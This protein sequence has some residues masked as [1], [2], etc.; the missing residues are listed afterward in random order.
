MII[1]QRCSL[2]ND[3]IITYLFIEDMRIDGDSIKI[4]LSMYHKF[5]KNVM[6]YESIIQRKL[7]NKYQS[8][9]KC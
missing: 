9:H 7:K 5:I 4:N 1:I 2:S 3:Y 8:S 6:T